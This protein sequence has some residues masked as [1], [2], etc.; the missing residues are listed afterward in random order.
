MGIRMDSSWNGGILGRIL[1]ARDHFLLFFNII[2]HFSIKKCAPHAAESL[3]PAPGT[4]RQS[5]VGA[6]CQGWPKKGAGEEQLW[7]KGRK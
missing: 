5:T 2:L 3:Q 6:A 1:S 7:R 4:S